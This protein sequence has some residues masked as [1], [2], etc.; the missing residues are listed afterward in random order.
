MIEYQSIDKKIPKIDRRL[1]RRW[2]NWSW[3][4]APKAYRKR[5]EL[6]LS[7]GPW[8]PPEEGWT[9]PN[10]RLQ[11]PT[12]RGKNRSWQQAPKAY[13]KR[14]ELVLTAGS[15]GPPEEGWTDRDS[16]LQWPTR[17]GKNWSWQQAPVAHRKRDELVLKFRACE[18]LWQSCDWTE[19]VTE[20]EKRF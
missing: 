15:R 7:A 16:R 13:Q 6:V 9:G 4:Q 17:R 12:R 8:G 11:R 10:S 1:T 18:G 19:T 5:D 3:Q 20:F 2:L 14:D